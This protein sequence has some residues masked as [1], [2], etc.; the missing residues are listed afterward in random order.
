M[1]IKFHWNFAMQIVFLDNLTTFVN[2]TFYLIFI[3]ISKCKWNFT[4]QIK[5]HCNFA[6]QI[7]FLNN[8]TNFEARSN[9]KETYGTALTRGQKGLTCCSYILTI[10]SNSVRSKQVLDQNTSLTCYIKF[11]PIV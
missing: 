3:K 9:N 6:M 11:H 7:K 1:Q 2:K 8:L 5:F 4:M 10:K